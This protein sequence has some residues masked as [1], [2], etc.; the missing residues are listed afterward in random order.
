MKFNYVIFNKN[1]KTEKGVIEAE[2]LSQATKLLISNGWYIKKIT[3]QGKGLNIPLSSL[4]FGRVGLIDKVLLVKH[5]STMIGSGISINEALEVI[6]DQ[7]TSSKFRNVITQVRKKIVAGQTLGDALAGYP[8]IFDPLFVNIIR[9]GERSGTLEK[10]LDY[11][12]NELEARL[13]LKRKI[14]AASFYPMIIF[15]ATFGL[16]LVL[17]YFVLPKIT[18]L[19]D[20][21]QVDLPLSTKLLL[22]FSA[23]MESHGGLIILGVIGFV[24]AFKFLV[25]QSFTKPVWHRFILSLPVAGGVIINYNLVMIS[26][27][28]SILLRSGLTIDDA[29]TISINTT[30]NE[31]YK[32]KLKLIL[33][34]IQKG[35]NLSDALSSFKQSK[36]KPLF[37]LLM[38]KMLG[39]GEKSGKLDE[40][41]LY[42]S[43]YYDKEVD[44]TTKSLTT[45]LEPFLLLFVGLIVGFIAISV[46]SPIYEVTGK[47]NR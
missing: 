30:L 12:A 39:V 19:F 13:D 2:S 36:R 31:V 9:V 4:S 20:S 44:N 17:S 43:E 25:S 8:K 45:V 32:K 11:L 10:N 7:S 33:P 14:K 1:N 16:G 15:A 37:S 38:I 21:L 47:F 35:K 27:T 22:D 41:L 6:V 18:K 40:S 42:L 26:R 28:L 34:Q 24:I 5:L 3:P 29:I 23:L 46:I